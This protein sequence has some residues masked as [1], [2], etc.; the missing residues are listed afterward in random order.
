MLKQL[1]KKYLEKVSNK[2]V[3]ALFVIFVIFVIFARGAEKM[4]PPSY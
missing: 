1:F 4:N 2:A 3:I